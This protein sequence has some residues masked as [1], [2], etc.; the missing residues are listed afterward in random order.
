MSKK[1]C[2]DCEHYQCYMGDEHSGPFEHRDCV[3]PTTKSLVTGNMQYVRSNAPWERRLGRCGKDAK[4]F[5]QRK[6]KWWEFWK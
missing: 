4:F 3:R 5:V 2:V 1:L 6:P